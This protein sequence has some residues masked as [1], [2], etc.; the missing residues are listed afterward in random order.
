MKFDV[1]D[2]VLLLHS[3][4]EGVI[5]EIL[6]D[7]SV[8]VN[9]K[10]IVF[11]VYI[12]QL[13]FP[14]FK[15]FTEGRA[16]KHKQKLRRGEDIPLEKPVKVTRQETGVF[17]SFLPQFDQASG[18]PEVQ[19]FKIHLI[20][21]T[22]SSFQFHYRLLLNRVLEIELQKALLPFSHIYLHDLSFEAFND[23]PRFTFTFSLA[24]PDVNKAAYHEILF[25][26]K[27]KQ[28]ITKL[29]E[30]NERQQ[31]TF[32][33]LLFE[34]YPDKADEK[35]ELWDI[36]VKQPRVDYITPSAFSAFS[37]PQYE[38]DLHIEKLTDHPET[39]SVI[40]IL[41]IQ[42]SEFQKQLDHAIGRRQH[43]FIVIHGVGKGRL[44]DEVHEILRRT[45]EVKY[46]VNQYDVRYGYGAT[47]IFF[48]Y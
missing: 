22:A 32:N 7:E 23:R 33:H 44:R 4:E 31:A 42:L 34:K 18:N 8:N 14:Y 43:S 1:G 26:P 37:L 45:P 24:E 29:E 27:A 38:I 5:T 13:D 3:G 47:E 15:R 19:L 39:L 10:G 46:F 2:T 30:L 41:A 40:E 35:E 6:D 16:A 48:S 17:L 21:E 28:L 25:K 20:N 11:P 36:P 9:V 12:D